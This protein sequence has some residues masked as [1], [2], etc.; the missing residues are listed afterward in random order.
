MVSSKGAEPT[1]G[2]GHAN[3]S[4]PKAVQ[5]S[6][7][8][9]ADADLVER[10]KNGDRQASEQLIRNYQDRAFALVLRM[11]SGDREKAM[12]LTQEAFLTALGKI[13][14]FEGKSSFYTWFYRILVNTCLDALRRRNRWRRLF[15]FHRP[16]PDNTRGPSDILEDLPSPDIGSNPGSALDARELRR[17]VY[18]ALKRLSDRQRMIFQ[19]KVFEEM[20]ISEIAQ[21]M[22]LAEGTVKSHLFRAT[23]IVRSA[24]ADW[25]EC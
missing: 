9:N 18:E 10:V 22:G 3:K 1:E 8:V 11:M 12:E 24:L 14:R 19:L 6:P 20:R 21:M 4:K 7:P 2:T 25:A 15:F 17:E 5:A 23:Q 13:N 16:N